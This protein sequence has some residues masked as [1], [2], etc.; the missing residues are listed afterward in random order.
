M[1]A[2]LS[3]SKR[4]WAF[5]E[6]LLLIFALIITAQLISYF[7]PAGEYQ[8]HGKQ[9]IANSF[10]HLDQ[11]PLPA[12]AFLTAIPKGMN[13]AADIIFFVFI[14]GGVL[15]I[16]RKSGA[17]DALIGSTLR[18][19]HNSRS[20]LVIGTT[21]LF[22]LGSASVGM[23]EEYMPFIPLLVTM[24]LA[25]KMDAIVGVALVYVGAGVGYGA[26]TL[27]PFTVVIA[28]KIAGL[29]PASGQAVRW[30][31]LLLF[32]LIGSLYIL[33][34]AKQVD[35]HPDRSLVADGDFSSGFALPEDI[36]LTGQRLLILAVF[37]AGV[38]LFAVGVKLWQW[39]LVELT[40]LFMTIGITT[41]VVGGISP[42]ETSR[43][44]CSGAAE[45][46]TA[47]LLIGFART[48]RVVLD[49]AKITDTI[50][51]AIA[52][53]IS[54]FGPALSAVAMLLVQA[55]INVLIPSGSGQ[56]YVTMPLMAPLADVTGVKRQVA[57]LAY[58]FGDGFGN[59][60]I[61]T[62]A[63]LM[64]MLGL[65]RIPYQRWVR[66][67]GPLLL[68]LYGI[69]AIVLIAAVKLGYR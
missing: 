48:I 29:P 58:Q 11:P 26:A 17:I 69:A 24:S 6:A 55:L 10:R 21:A 13:E 46:T 43:T 66:F 20:L 30:A 45:L 9:V 39:Y 1:D 12:T 28:Q 35:R 53:A 27:N 18:R 22:A 51:A 36:R 50:V 32:T 8:R 14:V 41:A 68:W 25:L 44:F 67:V 62:N 49:Q 56:A 37:A 34:Y 19:M 38:A 2:T 23:A 60:I 40:A 15:A 52:S 5:P 47:A 4:R 31:L 16:V 33:R 65:A 3:P 42:N 59:M 63:L 64:G 7:I 57:V 61:P 54:G